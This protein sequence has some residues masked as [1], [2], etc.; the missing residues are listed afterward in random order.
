PGTPCT[1]RGAR[2]ARAAAPTAARRRRRGSGAP[3][4]GGRSRSAL[5][6]LLVRLGRGRTGGGRRFGG[7]EPRLEVLP[8]L[9]P[10]L[11]QPALYRGDG[12]PGYGRD[13]LVGEVLVLPQHEDLPVL[14]R[15]AREEAVDEGDLLGLEEVAEGGLG[16]GRRAGAGL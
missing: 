12:V 4:L 3:R 16:G 14:R 10:R 11:E 2:T 9:P 6:R 8:Q 15:E 5:R 1:G 7:V 13:L